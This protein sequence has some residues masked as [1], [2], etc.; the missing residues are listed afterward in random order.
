MEGRPTARPTVHS[1]QRS[2]IVYTSREN[3]YEGTQSSTD[4]TGGA[5]GSYP[6]R[7]TGGGGV[8]ETAATGAETGCSIKGGSAS[9]GR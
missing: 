6:P 2:G 3:L 4:T 8:S 9:K 5:G 7:D 1:H